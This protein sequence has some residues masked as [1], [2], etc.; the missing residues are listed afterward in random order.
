MT[1]LIAL[2][3]GLVL[4]VWADWIAMTYLARPLSVLKQAGAPK[5][6][7]W[8]IRTLGRSLA[9]VIGLVIRSSRLHIRRPRGRMVSRRAG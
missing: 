8:L 1:T 7:R 4:L 3:V 6:L 2:V 9:L 5:A